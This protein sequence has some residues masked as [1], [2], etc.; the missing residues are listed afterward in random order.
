[1]TSGVTRAMQEG[2]NLKSQVDKQLERTERSLSV[3]RRRLKEQLLDVC[4]QMD[5]A[6]ALV[7]YVPDIKTQIQHYQDHFV[8]PE[9]TG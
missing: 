5:P 4:A 6:G 1:M 8:P 7:A 9:V 2:W 3:A